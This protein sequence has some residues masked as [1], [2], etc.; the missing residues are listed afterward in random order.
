MKVLRTLLFFIW[1]GLVSSCSSPR[2]QTTTSDEVIRSAKETSF[3]SLSGKPL[4]EKQLSDEARDLFGRKL[5]IAKATL[6]Q[7]P[8]SLDLIIWY[9]RRL[10]YLGKH[11]EAI[12]AYSNGLEKHPR[13][14]RLRRHRGHRYITTRQLDL[15]LKDFEKAAELAEGQP[16]AIE[17]DGLP[18]SQNIPLGNDQ[19]NIWYHY[20]LALYLS[21]Q[22]TEALMAYQQCLSVSDNDDLEAATSYWL[23]MTAMKLDKPGTAEKILADIS[24]ELEMIENKAY[25]DLLL[26]FKGEIAP[27]VLID[28]ATDKYG[29]LDPTYGY[30]IG[31]YYL[32]QNN[33][34]QATSVF[35]KALSGPSWESF[36][37]IAAE[38]EKAR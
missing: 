6:D 11:R 33:T 13:S 4:P 22:Y 21:G 1:I 36:G 10:A 17:P 18:N 28:H 7:Y 2:K 12:A 20:G 37:F 30:G 14:Y 25:L 27:E 5:A 38:A 32:S 29:V 15:A 9:G 19:F 26:L 23:Y 35:E 8:D 3:T 24:S 34:A 16:N 31:F